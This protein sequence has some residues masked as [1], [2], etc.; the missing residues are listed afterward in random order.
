MGVGVNGLVN[1]LQETEHTCPECGAKCRVRWS[2]EHQD[3]I[4]ECPNRDCPTGFIQIFIA[5]KCNIEG[6]FPRCIA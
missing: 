6:F 5:Y 1:K 4:V 3:M 2:E